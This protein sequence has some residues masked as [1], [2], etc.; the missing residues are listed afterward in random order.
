MYHD[1]DE[2]S[3]SSPSRTPLGHENPMST[4]LGTQ[5]SPVERLVTVAITVA[6]CIANKQTDKLSSLYIEIK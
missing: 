5:G 3:P 4:F 6:E 2:I 1:L